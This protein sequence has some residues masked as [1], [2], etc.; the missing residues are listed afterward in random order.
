MAL[1]FKNMDDRFP[2]NFDLSVFPATAGK[3][4]HPL[5]KKAVKELASAKMRSVFD[6]ILG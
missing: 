4:A 1:R 6:V 2:N 3:E 5:T